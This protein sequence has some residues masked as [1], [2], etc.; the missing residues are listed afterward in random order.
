MNTPQEEAPQRK[1]ERLRLRRLHDVDAQSAIWLATWSLDEPV[2]AV[3]HASSRP[4][5]AM[6][7]VTMHAREIPWRSDLPSR[8]NVGRAALAV[9]EA[10]GEARDL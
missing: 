8:I 4:S 9:R 5:A 3:I 6:L 10:L 2:W 1:H 7:T